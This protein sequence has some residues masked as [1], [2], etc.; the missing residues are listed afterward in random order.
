MIERDDLER[1]RFASTIAAEVDEIGGLLHQL[2]LLS[3]DLEDSDLMYAY[4]FI[5]YAY[6]LI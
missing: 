2:S 5:K 4:E 6:I 1:E 3:S